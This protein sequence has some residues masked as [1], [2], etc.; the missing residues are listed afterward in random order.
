MAD[1]MQPILWSILSNEN[2]TPFL[3]G[4]TLVTV[5]VTLLI[6]KFRTVGRRN[7]NLPP[8]P[9]TIPVLGNALEF[10][11]SFPHVK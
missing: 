10:P 8:G 11:T 3:T 9:K 5:V 2:K 1:T 4:A 7:K 6:L